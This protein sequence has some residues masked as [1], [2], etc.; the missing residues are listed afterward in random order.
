MGEKN[1]H[2][3][4][5][6]PGKEEK[7]AGL[8]AKKKF[9]SY[10]PVNKIEGRDESGRKIKPG[11]V[12]PCLV[13]IALNDTDQDILKQSKHIINFVYWH[14]KPVLVQNV[15]IDAMRN[16]LSEYS[17][18]RLDKTAVNPDEHFKLNNE[19]HLHKKGNIM[20]A[21]IATVKLTLP[22]LGHVLISEV[23]KEKEEFNYA[24]NSLVGSITGS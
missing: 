14:N 1:W 20:E 7:V 4:Y 15:E 5:T 21:N 17:C 23:R 9:T 16:F 6:R 13:F 3:V 12:F 2:V 24:R 22:S 19:L 10:L 18:T 11:P 8:L